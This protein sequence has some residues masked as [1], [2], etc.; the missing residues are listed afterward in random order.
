MAKKE[1]QEFVDDGRV[2]ANMNIEGMPYPIWKK[3]RRA[4]DEFGQ[5]KVARD[6][7]E[8]TR[9]EKRSISWGVISAYVLMAAVVGVAFFLLILFMTKVWLR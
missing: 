9:G 4:F 7:I 1:K 2:I 6:P 5:K 3:A 8:L